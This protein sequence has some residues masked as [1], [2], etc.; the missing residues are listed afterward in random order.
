MLNARVLPVLLPVLL[1]AAAAVRGD[2]II[3]PEPRFEPLAIKYHRVAV[4]ID[5]QAAHTDIPASGH[6]GHLHLS[7][8]CGR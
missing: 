1:L 7:A 8:T 4:E 5:D 6:R 2:G 3:I